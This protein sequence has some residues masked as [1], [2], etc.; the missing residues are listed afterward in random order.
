MSDNHLFEKRIF[1]IS[2]VTRA[3]LFNSS[4]HL[5][6]KYEKSRGTLWVHSYGILARDDGMIRKLAKSFTF[7]TEINAKLKNK[8]R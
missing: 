4:R 8:A 2:Y 3:L 7:V 1:S 6:H 5:H